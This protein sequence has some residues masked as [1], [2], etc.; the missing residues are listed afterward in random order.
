MDS[1][2]APNRETDSDGGGLSYPKVKVFIHSVMSNSLSVSGSCVRGIPQTR[3]LEWVSIPFSRGIL[4]TQRLNLGLSHSG[5]IPYYL[6]HEGSL[7]YTKKKPI[8]NHRR[9]AK[10]SSIRLRGVLSLESPQDA[11]WERTQ[12]QGHPR[13][14]VLPQGMQNCH[15]AVLFST[16]KTHAEHL[17]FSI[18]NLGM[19]THGVHL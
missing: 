3:I 12:K 6:S 11:A 14:W 9:V 13:C 8:L 15:T 18:L 19:Y 1:C 5:Q 7:S 16:L 17:N 10:P 4:P 2:C